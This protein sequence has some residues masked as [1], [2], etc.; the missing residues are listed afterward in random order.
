MKSFNYILWRQ[1]NCA[2]LTPLFQKI[3][4]ET[5]YFYYSLINK[6]T[7]AYKTNKIIFTCF[8][9]VPAFLKAE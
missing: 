9:T 3:L 4:E 1:K 7:C 5:L 6:N 2:G 8:D